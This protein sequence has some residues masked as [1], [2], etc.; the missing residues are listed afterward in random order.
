MPALIKNI[1][2]ENVLGKTVL[3]RAD[4]NIPMSKGKILDQTRVERVTPTIN[5]LK[6]SGAKIVICSHLGRPNGKYNK[7]Y[8]LEPLTKILSNILETNILFSNSCVG[9]EALDTK[10]SLKVSEILLLENVRFH[11]E[12]TKNSLDFAKEL[13]EGCDIFVND[14]FS[15]SHRAHSSLHAI[16]NF[17]PSYSGI[18]LDEEIKALTSVLSLPNTPVAAVVGGAKISTKINIIE[19]LI[20]KMDHL[21]IGGA[22][23]NTF[24][25]AEGFDVGKSLFEKDAVNIAKSILNKS[26]QLNCEII[27]PIDVVV[28]KS[29]E[30]NGK[31]NIVSSD[32]IPL[33]MMALDVGPKTIKKISFIFKNVKTLLW[34]GPLGAFELEPFG[35]GTFS[36][37]KLASNLT[38][39]KNLITVAGGGDTS[40]ALNKAGVSDTFTYVSSAGGAFLEWL[41]GIELPAISVLS[42]NK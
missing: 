35:E 6:S 7:N 2:N 25:V 5:F 22:M 37:A 20:T 24:L 10:R 27:L 23:A 16:T 4:L 31:A 26:K 30:A 42:N 8:T 1:I 12:E 18:F 14:A 34:N 40:S 21:I 29:F 3:V 36:L 38:I 19:N 11:E 41:E 15:C 39:S 9:Q 13:S 17:L 33:D 28:S 32:M